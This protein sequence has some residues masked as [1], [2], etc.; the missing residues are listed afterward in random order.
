MRRLTILALSAF[1]SGVIG[2]AG[3][4]EP[5]EKSAK[6][7]ATSEAKSKGAKKAA[8]KTPSGNIKQKTTGDTVGE[9]K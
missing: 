7:K 6:A 8:T 5:K 9:S 2:L 3:A 4:A 1:L